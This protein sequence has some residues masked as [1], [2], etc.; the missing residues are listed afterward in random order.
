[1]ASPELDPDDRLLC[2]L[3]FFYGDPPWLLLASLDAG[4]TLVAMR[5][6]S[7]SR[8]W[9]VV[10]DNSVTQ[11]FAIASIPSL[12]M[13]AP[14]EERDR[15]HG[16][17]FAVQVG[18]PTAQHAALNERWG[19]PWVEGYGLTETG[20]VVAM[21]LDLA[22][23]MTGSG[24]IGLPCPEVEVRLADETGAAV[25]VGTPGEILVRAPGLMRGYLG[26]PEASAETLRDGWLHTGDLGRADERG[27]LYF[28][29]RRKDMIRRSG[30]NVSAAEIEAVIRDHPA[31]LE[32]AVLPV[33]DE[34]R[35][36]EIKAHVAPVEGAELT[37]EEIVEHC[38]GRLAAHKLPRYVELRRR[39]FPRTPS[40][41]VRKAALRDEDT[42]PTASAWDRE[43]RPAA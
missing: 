20:L 17:R 5:R 7:V 25:P 33:P 40:M 15:D 27:F 39:P 1:M 10:R 34:L 26:R 21:P 14:P 22:E 24:S 32:V 19:F 3:Q 8:F 29:G 2:C 11:L 13:K 6:F 30:E 28:E 18:V 42:D 37:P 4:T 41:R 35:G 38:R 23:E 43:S 16:V 36:E 9:D 31:V 12:L